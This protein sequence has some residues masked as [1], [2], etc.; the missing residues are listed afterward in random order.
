M[1]PINDLTGLAP[2]TA[3]PRPG[4]NGDGIPDFQAPGLPLFSVLKL[5]D[6]SLAGVRCYYDADAGT[7]SCETDQAGALVLYPPECAP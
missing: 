3:L 4:S 2:G 1:D 6:G 5:G 7:V